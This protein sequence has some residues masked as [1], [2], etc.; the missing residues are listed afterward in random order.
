[1]PTKQIEQTAIERRQQILEYLKQHGTLPTP[2]LYRVLPISRTVIRYDLEYL[3]K[4][5][6][7]VLRTGDARK[8]EAANAYYWSAIQRQGKTD[9]VY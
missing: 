4:T 7:V 8:G 1:M 3:R 5:G 6:R 2:A 9:E